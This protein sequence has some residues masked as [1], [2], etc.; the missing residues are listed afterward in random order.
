MSDTI[1]TSN[2]HDN[3]SATA[4][5]DAKLAAV[6][7]KLAKFVHRMPEFPEGFL[8]THVIEIEVKNG[9]RRRTINVMVPDKY[10]RYSKIFHLFWEWATN[11]NVI[12]E[13]DLSKKKE[14]ILNCIQKDPE[15]RERAAKVWKGI[16]R[17][18]GGAYLHNLDEDTQ[19]EEEIR[20]IV[21]CV[22]EALSYCCEESEY[23][24]VFMLPIH[25]A[26]H[27]VE[28]FGD[29]YRLDEE[30]SIFENWSALSFVPMLLQEGMK[31]DIPENAFGQTNHLFRASPDEEDMEGR[32]N[33]GGLFSFAVSI[34]GDCDV[35][36]WKPVLVE[37]V[38]LGQKDDQCRFF[39][40]ENDHAEQI[41]S[42]FENLKQLGIMKKEDIHDH[43]LIK[44]AAEKEQFD[45]LNWLVEWDPKSSL[46]GFHDTIYH[47]SRDS[48]SYYPMMHYY[49]SKKYHVFIEILEV[50]LRHYPEQ[51]GLLFLE[52]SENNNATV[53]S[54]AY[55]N[56]GKDM[57]WDDIE[58]ELS[59][60][61]PLKLISFDEEANM[62][63]FM[64]AA[65]GESAD[66]DLLY[67]LM[68][69]DPEVWNTAS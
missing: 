39:Y 30:Y 34:A 14:I 27:R 15:A 4:L 11:S 62:F 8:P 31:Q 32:C 41:V 49:A 23:V 63:P 6:A 47:Y 66:L 18:V 25:S 45:L 24:G 58:E 68:R 17:Y 1:D 59:K 38:R 61:D 28:V 52:D 55:K 42:I 64:V 65:Q 51:L 46:K 16:V 69:K 44:E 53:I 13:D 57:A 33:R 56:V 21:Q 10:K 26:M 20:A 22:P 50:T 54:T 19:S 9:K 5:L 67:Y 60:I 37:L 40:L 35:F 43:K 2:D 12:S 36:E 3:E 48:R 29:R 7:E